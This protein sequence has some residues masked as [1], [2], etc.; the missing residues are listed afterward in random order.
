[1]LVNFYVYAF[2]R[3]PDHDGLLSYCMLGSMGQVQSIDSKAVFVIVGD[4]N[5]HDL[6]WLESVSLTDGHGSDALD[7]CNLAGCE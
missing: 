6:E 4:N 7:F 5:A 1:M 2:Y 3:N